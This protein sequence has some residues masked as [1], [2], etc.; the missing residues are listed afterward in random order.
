MGGGAD[1]DHAPQCH[2]IVMMQLCRSHPLTVQRLDVIRGQDLAAVFIR[3]LDSI[4]AETSCTA[5]VQKL[6]NVSITRT[7]S[8]LGEH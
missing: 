8:E 5:H 7:I 3:A 2:L 4:A 1:L 6:E